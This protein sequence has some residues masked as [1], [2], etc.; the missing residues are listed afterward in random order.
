MLVNTAVGFRSCLP[1][2]GGGTA[3]RD[4][5]GI[6]DKNRN[7][8]ERPAECPFHRSA[9]PLPRWGGKN[10]IIPCKKIFN[11]CVDELANAPK[12]G[13][14][15]IIGK[16]DDLQIVSLKNLRPELILLFSLLRKML[17]S[18]NFYDQFCRVAIKISD[19]IS[20]RLLSAKAR[21]VDAEIIIP[22]SIFLRCCML[23]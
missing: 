23:P 15:L 7:Q 10:L 12:I 9:V 17:R 5:R 16:T 20:N 11:G 18:V 6:F 8:P 3:C 4:G 14:N 21:F 1:N 19:K 2:G 13:V 22:Q